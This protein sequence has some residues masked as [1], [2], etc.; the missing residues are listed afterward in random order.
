MG[1]KVL[2]ATHNV[3]FMQETDQLINE[4]NSMAP[5]GGIFHLAM[6]FVYFPTLLYV[7]KGKWKDLTHVKNTLSYFKNNFSSKTQ[8]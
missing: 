3:K 5:V 4:A 7:V 6:V 2:V 1:V 8:I